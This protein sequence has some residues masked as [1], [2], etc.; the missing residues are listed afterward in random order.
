MNDD[1]TQWQRVL[2]IYH[3]SPSKEMLDKAYQTRLH[4]V[5]R[6]DYH[7]LIELDIAYME[8]IKWLN[9]E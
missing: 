9:G 6:Q 5:K 7:K 8:A 3:P 2:E 4:S 1:M